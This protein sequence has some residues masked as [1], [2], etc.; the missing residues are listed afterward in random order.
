[1]FSVIIS[2][3]MQECDQLERQANKLSEQTVELKQVIR[4]LS[5]LSGMDEVIVK[6]RAQNTEMD[7]ERSVLGQMASGLGQA[8]SDYMHC[9]NRICDAVEQ[10]VILY[11][12]EEIKR[13]DFS[14]ITNILNKM[15]IQ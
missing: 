13:N 15:E 7:S 3:V 4:E 10:N 11:A 2:Q 12:Q 14:N 1:M 5:N 9:E 8:V 6:L